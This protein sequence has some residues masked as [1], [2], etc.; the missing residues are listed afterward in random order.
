VGAWGRRCTR[1]ANRRPLTDER[2]HP[3]PNP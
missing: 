2:T 1:S 3:P